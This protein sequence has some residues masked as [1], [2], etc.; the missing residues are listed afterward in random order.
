M[1]SWYCPATERGI[2]VAEV[3]ID[4]TPSPGEAAVV[5]VLLV[6][7]LASTAEYM[8]ILL[9]SGLMRMAAWRRAAGAGANMIV[10]GMV[11]NKNE[12]ETEEGKVALR[13]SDSRKT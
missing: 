10:Y 5:E 3:V 1:G 13:Y 8:K 7:Q 4:M 2:A 11:A 9:P 12:E 6:V